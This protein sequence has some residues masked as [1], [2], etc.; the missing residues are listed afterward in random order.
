MSYSRRQLYAMGEPLGDGATRRAVGGKVIYGS[1]GGGGNAE[2]QTTIVDLPEWAKPYA[3]ESLGKASALTSSPYQTYGGER[4][5]QFNPLQK[6]AFQSA[7]QQQVAGQIGQATGLAGLA[8]QQA[9]GAGDFQTGVFDAERVGTSSF[10]QPGEASRFMSPYM[11]AVVQ[12]QMESAQRQADIAG[13]QRGAQAVRAGAFGGSR[14]AVENAEAA[15]ALASQKGE[16]QAQGLQS[17][18]QQAQSQFNQEQDARMRAAMANQQA[19]FEAQRATE[20]S[21]QFGSNIGLQG[22]QTALQGAGQLGQLGQQQFGQQMGITDLQQ[23]LGGQ[24]RAATQEILSN[25]YQDFLNQQ[26]APYDQLSFMSSIIRGTP[27]GQTTAQYQPAASPTSQLLG[28][29]TA[30]AGAYGAYQ[31][32]QG[33]AAGGEVKGYAA[34][35]TTGITGLLDRVD[36]LSDAQLGQMQQGE[37]RPLTAAAVAEEVM[38]RQEM[39]EGMA[40]QQAMMMPPPQ[41]T[42]AEEELA[43]LSALPAPNLEGMGEATMAD[44]G[45]VAFQAGGDTTRRSGENFADYRRRMFELELQTQRDRNAAV[46][47]AR[48]A[49]RQRL[50]AQR[51]D[52]IIPP[53]PFFDRNPLPASPA[54]QAAGIKT[55]AAP[56]AAQ[57][58]AAAAMAD[59]ERERLAASN[60]T[61]LNKAEV[62][63]RAPATAAPTTKENVDRGTKAGPGGLPQLKGMQAAT[64][65]GLAGLKT[66]VEDINKARTEAAANRLERAKAQET[67]LGEFGTEQ[68]KRLKAREEGLK[69]AEDKNF[70]MALIEAGLAMMSGTSANAFENIGKGALVG[71]KAYTTGVERIQNRKE[72]LDDAVIALENAKRSDKRVSQERMDRLEA[73]VDNAA[74]ANAEALYQFGSK[75]L[76]M[77]RQDAQFATDVALKQAQIAASNRP[78]SEMQMID[79]LMKEEKLTY[80][81]ALKRAAELSAKP[82]TPF[83]FKDSYADYLKTLAGKPT[84]E[85]ALTYEQYVRQFALPTTAAATNKLPQGATVLPR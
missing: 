24:Q 72:K 1:G 57:T 51:P 38:R 40:Q 8:S 9:L 15:R 82:A 5:A 60:R 42:V 53:S 76:D 52:G 83:N 71:T 48:E 36:S 12:R 64:T 78:S 16:I 74:T 31:G 85:P 21:R 75:Q 62:A 68:A 28:L 69:G 41:T 13:T 25:Q 39:R 58:P 46:A 19:G 54:M 63:A 33:R 65:E 61:L 47:T 84:L 20:Q 7:A 80:A 56:V 81:Q 34:G 59:P 30:G 3:K 55:N 43:G 70:N 79:R 27:M 23:Q 6:Q 44:G 11:D 37:Q 10:A 26:R 50:L 32:A 2:K 49:E 18:F 45:I 67:E 4:T 77:T 66:Q 14:Q 29:A 35:G 22:A 73:D 17:A